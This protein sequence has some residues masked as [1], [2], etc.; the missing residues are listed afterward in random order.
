M[1]APL[2]ADGVTYADGTKASVDQMAQDVVQFLT[3]AGDPHMEDRKRTGLATLIF[4]IV[5]AGI[6]YAAKRKLWSDVH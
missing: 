3:W 1:P 6:M 5:F 4:L 2:M